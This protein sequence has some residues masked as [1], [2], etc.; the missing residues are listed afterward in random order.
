MSLDAYAPSQ[1]KILVRDGHEITNP[2]G[3]ITLQ[4]GDPFVYS[5]NV[6]LG[7]NQTSG[8]VLL[9]NDDVRFIHMGTV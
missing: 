8:D 3:W 1:E 7:I 9:T 4:A 6:N 2:P 5:R